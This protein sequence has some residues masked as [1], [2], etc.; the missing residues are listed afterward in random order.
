MDVVWRIS[1]SVIHCATGNRWTEL[2]ALMRARVSVEQDRADWIADLNC[3]TKCFG[4]MD[5]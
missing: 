5:W 3:R 1:K 4:A 2:R